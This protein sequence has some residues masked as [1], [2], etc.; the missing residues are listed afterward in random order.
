MLLGGLSASYYHEELAR[1]PDVDFVIARRFDRGA[2]PDS[3]CSLSGRERSLDAVGEPDLEAPRTAASPVNPLT[4]VPDTL[5]YV[6]VPAYDYRAAVDLQGRQPQEPRC[7]SLDWLRQP[8]TLLLLGARLRARALRDLRRIAQRLPPDLRPEPAGVPLPGQAGGRRPPDLELFT[9][10]D[11]HGSRSAH[12]RHA[13]HGPLPVAPRD[14]QPSNEMIFE[15]Y[16]PADD[17]FF[18]AVERSIPAW[19]LEIT[20]E[21]PDERLRRLNGKF[22]FTND[23]VEAHDRECARARLQ[24]DRCLL[25]DRTAAPD[26]RRRAGH[27]GLLRAPDWAGGPRPGPAV[28]RAARAVPGSGKPCVRRARLRVP[29]VLLNA[30][31][32]LP[33][34]AAADVAADSVGT[35]PM[36]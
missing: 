33:G 26:L 29:A 23:A 27:P 11:L 15:L 20:L 32:S 24:D 18:E 16:A 14:I 12:G 10:T 4:F 30:R 22:P 7:P 34:R 17:T 6:D 5:D 21:S 13:E 8:I 3:C 31:R 36:G 2:S 28:R 25:H 35:K 1:H 19:S 9:R